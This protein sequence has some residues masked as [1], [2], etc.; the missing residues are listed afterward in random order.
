MYHDLKGTYWWIGIK[1]DVVEYVS[2]CLTCHKL[3]LEHQRPFGYLHP[4][5]IL[6]WKWERISMNFV[7]GDRSKYFYVLSCFPHAFAT[8]HRSFL[9]FCKPF[10]IC[11]CFRDIGALRSVLA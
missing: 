3:K 4:L 6:E 7:V 2:K 8:F 9:V 10:S 1:K 11:E 5:P